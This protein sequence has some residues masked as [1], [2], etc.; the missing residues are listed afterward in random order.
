MMPPAARI[1]AE[2]FD[3][4][5]HTACLAVEDSFAQ[6]VTKFPHADWCRSHKITQGGILLELFKMSLGFTMSF[7]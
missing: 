2:E 1:V 7:L 5:H 3:R 4:I 6:Q